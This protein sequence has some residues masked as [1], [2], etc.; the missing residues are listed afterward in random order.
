[1]KSRHWTGQE[2][3]DC[4]YCHLWNEI[5]EHEAETLGGSRAALKLRCIRCGKVFWLRAWPSDGSERPE[6]E[7]V[8]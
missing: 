8:P 2:G 5:S 4:P 7:I 1:M 6:L 3:I